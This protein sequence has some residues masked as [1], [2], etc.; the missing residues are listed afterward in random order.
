MAHRFRLLETGF[1]DAYFNM[2]LDEA[3][4]ES[5]SSGTQAPTL[6]LY[7]WNPKAISLGYFQGAEE[8]LD[9]D[10]CKERGVDIVRRI[11]GGGAVFHDAE[12]TYSI[13]IPESHP[14]ACPS[15]LDS[16]SLLLQGLI[17]GLASIGVDSSFVPINDIVHE[18][19]KISGNAQTRKQH[20]ILQHGTILIDVDVEQM[21]SLLK[22]PKEKA[23]GKLIADVK[24][25][26]SSLSA[27]LGTRLDFGELSKSIAKGFSQALDL[28][29][30]PENPSKTE[31]ERAKV[32]A[33]DKFSSKAWIFRR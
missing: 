29:L 19:K 24:A 16:Y 27:I 17:Q 13:V 10:A 1:N 5:V 22:V 14:L 25:R 3:V 30:E 15:I 6:R 8:E 26:V 4:L 12:L 7:G 2:G 23:Q 33:K 11:T 21:F 32:L 18:G 31:I 20:C 28:A 9:I